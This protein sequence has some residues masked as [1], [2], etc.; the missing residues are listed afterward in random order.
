MDVFCCPTVIM[1]MRG[2]A[3]ET[4]GLLSGSIPPLSP[5]AAA[6]VK[7]T[8]TAQGEDCLIY[9]ELMF[10]LSYTLQ[11]CAVFSLHKCVFCRPPIACSS[12]VLE[13]ILITDLI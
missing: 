11:P 12:R 8:S 3:T 1:D 2:V 5:E 4:A 10:I 9:K 6:R 7:T 13:Q